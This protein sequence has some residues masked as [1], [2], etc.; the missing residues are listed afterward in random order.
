VIGATR[1][2]FKS[3]S[4]MNI[5]NWIRSSL[6]GVLSVATLMLAGS[7][8]A[9]DHLRG[10]VLGGGGP[11]SNSTVTLWEARSNAPKKLAEAK[12]NGQ[13]QFELRSTTARGADSVLYLVATGGVPKSQTGDNPA[14]TL[15]A[16]LGNKPPEKVTIN[17]FTT[18]ASV[19]TNLQFLDGP[20]LQGYALGLRIAAGNVPNF[21]D[22]QTGGWGGAIQDPLNSGQTPTMS[23]FA[24]LADVL[25]GCVTM[26][27][28]DACSSLFYA[29][30]SPRNEYPKD[31]LAAVE[32]IARYPWYPP[33]KLFGL[34]NYLYPA[35]QD[36]NLRS[37]PFMPYLNFTPSAW[38]LPL[39]FDGG[40]YR[41][42][43]K[44]MFDSEG[45]FWVSNNFTVGWQ[46]QDSLWQGHASK[47]APNGTA[48]SPITTGFAGGG[49]EGG[50]FG[51]AVDAK[52]NAWFSS[53]GSKSIAVFDKNGKPLTP[54]DGITFNGRLG[55]MQ[56][57]I[58]TPSGD[59]WALCISKSQLVYF[60]KGDISN[61]RI[62]CEGDSAEPCK[63]FKGPFHLGIDQQNRIWVDSSAIDHLT[64]FP[65]SD[66]SKT[67]NFKTGGF[68][69]SGLAIDSQGNVW[70]TNRFGS[71]LL[72]MAHL[73]DMGV[74]FKTSG[75]TKA[76]D[77]L[78]KIMSEQK[79]GKEGG[80][81]VVLKPDG[82]QYPGS[83]F[84]GGG[85]P[86]PWAAAVDGND[87]VW[88][89]NLAM[90]SS[91]IVELC[92]VRTETCPPG[93]KTGDQISPPGGYVG[94][95]LQMQVDVD[96]AGNVWVTNNWQDID[97]CV[98]TPNDAVST[99]CGGQG[100]VIF[101]GMAKPVH[102][103]Q[104]GPARQP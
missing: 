90:P 10:R 100:V 94:G 78:T 56:G 46:G 80:S 20:T 99:R 88:I 67:E 2:Q 30:T 31:T 38:I 97:S 63:S 52:D 24:T 21:V 5:S 61:G 39:K 9:T 51:V 101:Y 43:G 37:V 23:N 83:P 34:L 103:P 27:R 93:M 65:A 53:Y 64:R 47:F 3:E 41:A 44:G 48:L 85:L 16:V 45:N 25:A 87:N 68:N 26:I 19:W 55:L 95:G 75:V 58:A 28:S 12:T 102:A 73:V 89:S 79:G 49:M 33:E 40:G 91:P 11:I 76:S 84:T 96:P 7:A 69:S 36:H 70:V 104:I 98:G 42:G 81:V 22:L 15:L 74:R 6:V 18:L 62:V 92:G 13:G 35:P 17:E 77:Y 66:P 54:P 57:I 50:T 82:T 71:G 72:G 59:I 86:G 4:K 14:I 8:L 29:A 1:A 32:N 60:P